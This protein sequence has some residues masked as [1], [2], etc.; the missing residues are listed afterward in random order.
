MAAFPAYAKLL[1]EGFGENPEPA[2][3]RTEMESGPPK[4]AKIKSRVMVARPVIYALDSKADYLA[5]I[6]WFKTGVNYGSDFFD[7]T[8]PLDG[9]V[10]NARIVGGK[11]EARPI[12]GALSQW[13]VSFSLEN[14]SA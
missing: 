4:Q 12:N 2:V 7:W 1:L 9:L 5:F 10:K 8:D 3:L 6:A 11:I 14:W 13:R